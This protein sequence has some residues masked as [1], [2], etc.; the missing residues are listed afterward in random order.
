MARFIT[1]VQLQDAN[2][3]DY[4]MLNDEMK[5]E[6]FTLTSKYSFQQRK[7]AP[8]EMADKICIS[9]RVGVQ[10]QEPITESLAERGRDPRSHWPNPAALRAFLFLGCHIQDSACV[11]PLIGF[12]HGGVVVFDELQDTLA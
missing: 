6:S 2:E 10:R 1:R 4:E 9:M 5:K 7:N 12:R 3:H 11:C 8:K